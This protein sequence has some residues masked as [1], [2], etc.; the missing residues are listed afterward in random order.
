MTSSLR[1]CLA[2]A[3]VSLDASEPGEPVC[4]ECRVVP[5]RWYRDLCPSCHEARVERDRRL[6]MSEAL[7][8]LPESYH[9]WA[10]VKTHADAR[11]VKGLAEWTRSSGSLL[12][13]GPT[14]IGKTTAVCARVRAMIEA[15][16]RRVHPPMLPIDAST[17]RFCAGIRWTDARAL[18]RASIEW[19]WGHGSAPEVEQAE[20]ATL[21]VLDELGYELSRTDAIHKL[22]EDR[23]KLQRLTI[24]TSGLTWQELEKRYGD[25][26]ARKL[27]GGS[28]GT[29][30]DCHAEGKG[31][32]H[33]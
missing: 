16:I 4:D 15:T 12:V 32:A 6:T 8:T 29:V 27:H 24:T 14:G 26:V 17:V 3:M 19:K 28:S 31:G 5:V 10:E 13:I 9:T 21:L 7:R 25:A 33:A 23:Y 18:V 1:D 2:E 11:I 20:R 30:I 22:I